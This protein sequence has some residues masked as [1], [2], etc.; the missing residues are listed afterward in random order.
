[1]NKKLHLPRVTL[2]SA[3]SSS[4]LLATSPSDKVD[5]TQ[6]ALKISLR[7]IEFGSVKLLTSE[8]PKKKY[9]N[10]EYISIPPMNNISDYNR[11]VI[12][13]LHKY[14]TTTHCLLI[15]ADG[16][17]VDAKKLEK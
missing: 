13:D 12:E 5:M 14:F 4:E 1:M 8:S 6:L 10:I 2:L 16:W 7:E 3:A 17:V 15:Q 9:S 11:F